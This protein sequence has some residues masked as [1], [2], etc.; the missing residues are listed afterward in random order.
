VWLGFPI[1]LLAGCRTEPTVVE[2][3]GAPVEEPVPPADPPTRVG[4]IFQRH[5]L[6]APGQWHVSPEGDRVAARLDAGCG[7]WPI[8]S[9]E[10]LGTATDPAGTAACERWPVLEPISGTSPPTSFPPDALPDNATINRLS[11]EPGRRWLVVEYSIAR[12]SEGGF[13]VTRDG[14]L[15]GLRWERRASPTAEQVSV[16]WHDGPSPTWFELSLISGWASYATQIRPVS[17]RPIEKFEIF[18]FA[19][20]KPEPFE[21]LGPSDGRPIM[22]MSICELTESGGRECKNT[23]PIPPDCEPIGGWTNYWILACGRS[24]WQRFV[25]SWPNGVDARRTETL[26]GSDRNDVVWV[27]AED[28]LA[29]WSKQSGLTIYD[30]HAV[31]SVAEFPQVI[32]LTRATLDSELGLALVRTTAGLQILDIATA[33]LGPSLPMIVAPITEAAFAPDKDAVALTDGRR[34]HVWRLSSKDEVSWPATAITKLAWRQDST[35]LLGSSVTSGPEQAWDPRTGE[36]VE[37]WAPE[38]RTRI[39]GE[40][41]QLDPTWRWAIISGQ[42]TEFVEIIRLVDGLTL[43]AGP[44]GAITPSGLY[45]HDS[46]EWFLD[47]WRV[48][49]GSSAL[50]DDWQIEKL[51]DHPDHARADLVAAFFA[52]DP[53]AQP[54]W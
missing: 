40:T 21:L 20:D 51:T 4:H 34:V 11:W 30:D 46:A 27:A 10:F 50:A 29:W 14:Q 38:L 44:D 37:P 33:K 26:P 15:T 1:V 7:V 16:G 24:G 19:L 39:E 2:K 28:R 49:F 35:L 5:E 9:R 48:G 18:D 6:P 54:S 32:E 53:I 23:E 45:Q 13:I 36:A 8:D 52:N 47:M 43:Y 41:A 3:A 12:T 25:M 42:S 31:D 17:E 22:R